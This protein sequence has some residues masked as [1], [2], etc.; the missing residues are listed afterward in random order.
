[1]EILM[2]LRRVNHRTPGPDRAGEIIASAARLFQQKGVRAVSID[3][4]VQGAGIAKGTFYLY[5]KTK[6]DLLAKLTGAAV[7]QMAQAA[8]TASQ[9][10]GQILDRFA[11]AIV[12]MQHVDRKQQYLV[13]ALNH[14][15]NSVLHELANMALVHQVAPVL[16]DIVEQGKSEGIFDVEDPLATLEFLLAGQAALLGGGRFNWSPEAYAAR[17]RATLIIVERALGAKNGAILE[18]LSALK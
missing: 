14:P 1:M 11:A 13:D 8:R 10:E 7:M 3:D 5:F 4:I 16:A 9:S 6:D 17:F 2:V 18:R 12:A 15:E